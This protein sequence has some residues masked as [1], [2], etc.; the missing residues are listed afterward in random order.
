MEVSVRELKNRLSE[1]LRRVK[2]GEEIVVTSRGKPVGRLVGPGPVGAPAR[3]AGEAALARLNALPYVRPGDGKP[4][5]VSE[6]PMEW[7]PGQKTLAELV[8]EDRE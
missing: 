3:S 2:A 4:L 1:Y 8:L 7:Q 5:K 6:R